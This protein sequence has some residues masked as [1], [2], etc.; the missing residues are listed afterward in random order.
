MVDLAMCPTG[1]NFIFAKKNDYRYYV[2]NGNHS[3]CARV[4]LAKANPKFDAL[5][6]MQAWIVASL[7]IQEAR[8]LARSH[9][10]D[11]KFRSKMTTIQWIPHEICG[12]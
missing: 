8:A 4:D 3:A 1:A 7:T 9:N 10:V 12:E 6:R 2:V 5:R 11:N